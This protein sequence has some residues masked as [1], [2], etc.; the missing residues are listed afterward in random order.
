MRAPI[1]MVTPPHTPVPF[2]R[3][4]EKAYLPSPASIVTGRGADA[5]EKRPQLKAALAEAGRLKCVVVVVVA[6]LD[7]F[8]RDVPFIS[9]LMAPNAVHCRRIGSRREPFMFHLYAARAEK[10]RHLIAKGPGRARGPQ[11]AG[12]EARRPQREGHPVPRRGEGAGRGA[13]TDSW[14]NYSGKSARA[15]A[16]EL[17][18][19]EIATPNGGRW[20][21]ETVIR[22][23]RRLEAVS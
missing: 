23:Q 19:R 13:A 6:K 14:P 22:V 21:A 1:E 20:H 17:D 18:A 11:G 5:L 16:G 9:D 15:I 10:E 7:R 12:R 3:E 2:A 4:L 8:S